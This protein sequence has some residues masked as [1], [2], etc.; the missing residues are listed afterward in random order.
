MEN[1]KAA[2]EQYGAYRRRAR[3]DAVLRP[4]LDRPELLPDPTVCPLGPLEASYWHFGQSLR[5]G[6]ANAQVD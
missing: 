6:G 1:L 2:I 4:L 5:F 3:N